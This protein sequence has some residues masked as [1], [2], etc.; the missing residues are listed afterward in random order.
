MMNFSI[1]EWDGDRIGDVLGSKIAGLGYNGPK[2]FTYTHSLGST[3]FVFL[4]FGA[5]QG[6]DK[7]LY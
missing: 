7:K 5:M 2:Q 4:R 1:A 3:K 6:L